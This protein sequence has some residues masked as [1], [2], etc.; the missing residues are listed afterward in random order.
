MQSTQELMK[1]TQ[2]FFSEFWDL[3][4][5]TKAVMLTTNSKAR[6]AL[7]KQPTGWCITMLRNTRVCHL[8]GSVIFSDIQH[9]IISMLV[10]GLLWLHVMGKTAFFFL[11]SWRMF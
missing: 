5:E 3:D 9:F 2:C 1:A 11:T 8:R 7:S 4:V 10:N 6:A